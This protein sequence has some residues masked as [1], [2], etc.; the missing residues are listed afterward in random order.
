MDKK[1]TTS[2]SSSS[3]IS[4]LGTGT[5][6]KITS[7]NELG[8]EIRH[9]FHEIQPHYPYVTEYEASFAAPSERS[10]GSPRN[11]INTSR[12][13]PESTLSR[14]STTVLSDYPNSF[15]LNMNSKLWKKL[16]HLFKQLGDDLGY[17]KKYIDQLRAHTHNKKYE[18]H[19][20][21][22]GE[23]KAYEEEYEGGGGRRNSSKKETSNKN[24]K[25]DKSLE[26]AHKEFQSIIN[27]DNDRRMKIG[28]SAHSAD[29]INVIKDIVSTFELLKGE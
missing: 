28:T 17:D 15:I 25:L 2:S 7:C 6:S 9:H 4:S 27:D 29:V 24:S 18:G 10:Y 19:D 8:D 13:S 1:S 22:H 5:G 21:R 11:I 12:E 3:T 23:L 14:P 20:Y 16:D 26:K